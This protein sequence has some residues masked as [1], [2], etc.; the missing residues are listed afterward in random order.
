MQLHVDG[1]SFDINNNHGLRTDGHY[2]QK[3]NEPKRDKI[4]C[5]CN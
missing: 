3:H 4:Q 1:L 2:K 5:M